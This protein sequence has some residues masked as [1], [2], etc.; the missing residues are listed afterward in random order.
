M[1]LNQKEM[2]ELRKEINM[3][4]QD[5]YSSLDPRMTTGEL[6]E[7]P[8]IIHNIGTPWKNEKTSN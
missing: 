7:E 5:P 8:M 1:K 3:V 6:I 2:N 4:F